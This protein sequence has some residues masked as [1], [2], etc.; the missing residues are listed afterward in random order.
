MQKIILTSA[1]FENKT[2]GGVFLSLVKKAPEEI[3]VLFIPTAADFPA[4]IEVLPKCMNDLLSLNIPPENIRVFD[5]HRS[6]NIDEMSAFDAVYFT[7]G[8]QQYLLQRINETGFYQPIKGFVE[9]G[10]VYV[11]VSAG[12]IIAARNLPDNLGYLNAVLEV[13][14]KTG[15][16]AGVFDNTN[17]SHIDLTDNMAVLIRD[18]VYEIVE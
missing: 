3:R 9:K 13:H 5:L 8:S 15:T 2:I 12:S 14:T 18:G 6:L 4:A 7:G 11:G 17:V 16:Q 10:G 1:G